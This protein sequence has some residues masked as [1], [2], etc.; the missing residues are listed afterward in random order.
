MEVDFSI[1]IPVY[2]AQNSI[3]KCLESLQC[4]TIASF[5][6]LVIDDGS[7]DN[8]GVICDK[9][10][11][12][13]RRFQVIHQRNAGVSSARNAGLSLAKGK[14]IAFVDSDDTVESNFL[15]CLKEKFNSSKAE[16]VFLGYR[17][18][19]SSGEKLKEISSDL[20]SDLFELQISELSTKGQFGYTWVK[21]FRKSAINNHQFRTNMSLFED[22]IFT[23]EV[24]ADCHSLD[25]ITRPIYNYVC[26]NEGTLMTKTHQDYCEL[27]D[28]V[29]LA[30]KDLLSGSK[31]CREVLEIRANELAKT[32]QYYLFEQQIDLDRFLESASKCVFLKECTIDT[33]F[34]KAIKKKIYIIVKAMRYVYHAKI[35]V[36][37]LLKK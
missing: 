2:N 32:F 14:F 12:S 13:D 7:S 15:E 8:S 34:F 21:A 5:E 23:C 11:E 33:L 17:M 28:Q 27:Q 10:S 29:Y 4:Q 30:W 19:S 6:A 36:A 20:Q 9:I 26:W 22:E 24:L 37:K 35:R 18:Y 3:K 31:Y 16:V 1:I 25:V